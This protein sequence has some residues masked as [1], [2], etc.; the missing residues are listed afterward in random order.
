M[1]ITPHLVLRGT[2]YY[3]RM[4]VP[5]RLVKKVGRAEVSTSL[6]TVNR[7]EDTLRCRYLSNSLDVFFQGLCMQ[8]GPTFEE[9]DAEIKAYFQKALN[10]SLEYNLVFVDDLNVAEELPKLIEE[11]QGQLKSG[12][13]SQTVQSD[14]NELLA[15][16]LPTQLP[17]SDDD[18][19]LHALTT[20]WLRSSMRV[21]RRFL[22]T[23]GEDV[24]RLVES[25]REDV[26]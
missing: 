24:L 25:G 7:K 3:F 16:L 21:R 19:A 12:K 14:A 5:R 8:K 22:D 11:Y 2:T 13:F 18:K 1:G 15:P 26:A 4:A 10:W 23:Y 9:I 17:V 20:V 6:R